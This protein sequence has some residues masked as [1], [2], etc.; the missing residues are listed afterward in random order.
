MRKAFWGYIPYDDKTF[1]KLWETA[2]FVLDANILLNLY[3]YSNNTKEKVLNS[4]DKISE[5]IWIPNQ[6]GIEYFNNRVSIILEQSK[7]YDEVLEELSFSKSI[8]YIKALRHSTLEDKKPEIIELL[9]KC[10]NKIKE[11][12]NEDKKKSENIIE[13]DY[14]LKK[15]VNIFDGKVGSSLTD[16]DLE[17]Y[18]KD[19]DIRYS[20]KIPPGYKDNKKN[21]DKKYGDAINWLEII[22]YSKNNKKNIIYITDDRK[23]DWIEIIEGKK[24]GP[25]KELLNEFYRSTDGNI[26]YIYNTYSFLEA[27]NKYINTE[28]NIGKDVMDEIKDLDTILND[29]D[30][31]KIS[32]MSKKIFDKFVGLG[33]EPNC[34]IMINQEK[35]NKYM[36]I[37]KDCQEGG[38]DFHL[39]IDDLKFLEFVD[40][41]LVLE[42]TISL[43]KNKYYYEL[44]KNFIIK[45]K[46]TV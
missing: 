1:E 10:E 21:D 8:D 38:A 41:L 17:S 22:K 4:L 5:R 32:I 29:F 23:E 30:S 44:Y 2:D 16:K 26:I 37:I 28:N 27:F 35:F 3:R 43:S 42:P 13:D 34:L 19:I 12:I 33:V 20:K 45:N 31:K 46:V 40:N 11:I 15:I 18:K 36:E 25:R 24:I 7:I 14:I 39:F 6:T 9:Q